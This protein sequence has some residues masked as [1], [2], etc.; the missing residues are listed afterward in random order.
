MASPAVNDIP[1][2][3]VS[4]NAGSATALI[5]GT[6][7]GS[8]SP[9]V[10]VT[11]TWS[12]PKGTAWF[13][14][15]YNFTGENEA[16][17]RLTDKEVSGAVK[18]LAAWAQVSGVAFKKVLDNISTV[19]EIRFAK[20]ANGPWDAEAHAYIPSDDPHAGDIWMN[21][22]SWNSS[23][24]D[25]HRPGTYAYL[26]LLHEIGH[27]LG[28]KHPFSKS[29]H[30][31]TK[32]EAKYD[33]CF[34]TVM[35]YTAT[36]SSKSASAD[37]YPTTPMYLDLVAIQY[38]YGRDQ[39]VNATD[40]TYTFHK[41]RKYWQ[42]IDDAGGTDT[43][44]YSGSSK[45]VIDL[46]RGQFNTLSDRINFSNGD[47]SRATVMIGPDVVI[48][49]AQGGSG[50]DTLIGNSVDNRLKGMHGH[51][52]LNAGSGNDALYGGAGNDY[53]RGGDGNDY[54]KGG[55]GKDHFIFNS[56]FSGGGDVDRISD[57]IAKDDTIRLDD[58]VVGGLKTGALSSA[59]FCVGSSAKDSK[60]R[61]IYDKGTGDL[62]YDPDG[63]G[64]AAQIKFATLISKPTLSAAD[65]Y[66]I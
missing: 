58:K 16:W 9:G 2:P 60:D 39:T 49:R 50:S 21:V 7:W 27:A 41:G 4:V 65:F 22:N 56:A 54:L 53:L 57:F 55:K 11:I 32:L 26:T 35:S 47:S 61:I 5:Y 31:A 51:D 63:T 28:L 19:G 48:E 6:K 34:Y 30:N 37:F 20:T 59:R 17:K 3:N 42:T 43:I 36:P 10:G 12:L 62:F 23:G 40:T 45:C 29:P 46:R 15:S 66:I 33:S 8:S 1:S 64:A 25:A 18:A 13:A 14:D 44:V 24:T 52:R 38:L